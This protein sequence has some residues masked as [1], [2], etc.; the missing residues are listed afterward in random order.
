MTGFGATA[1]AMGWGKFLDLIIVSSCLAGAL[2]LGAVIIAMVQRWRRQEEK[3]PTTDAQLGHFRS[4][5]E[6]GEISAEEYKR[7][8]ATILGLPALRPAKEPVV[9]EGIRNDVPGTCAPQEQ[10][11][12][13]P[14]PAP[15]P[16]DGIQPS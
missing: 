13:T 2:L 11:A 8:R 12:S 5:Y 4:L 10:P 7:L 6:R 15:P 9:S 1:A 16:P 14:Q 3:P